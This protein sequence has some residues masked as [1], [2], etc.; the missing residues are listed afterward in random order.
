MC[1][2]VDVCRSVWMCIE[3]WISV[4]VCGCV[5]KCVDGCGCVCSQI[6]LQQLHGYMS[7]DPSTSLTVPLCHCCSLFCVASL[8]MVT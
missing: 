3:V 5:Y 8:A 4:E 6:Q 1:R 7:S 2:S